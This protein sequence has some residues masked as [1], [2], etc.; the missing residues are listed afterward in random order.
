MIIDK[1]FLRFYVLFTLL[2]LLVCAVL[3]S[4]A[5]EGESEVTNGTSVSILEP[6][7]GGYVQC[8]HSSDGTY[9]FSV[10]GTSTKVYD[11]DKVALLLWVR[12]VMPPSETPGFYLQRKPIN[13][14]TRIEEN[15]HWEGI[16]QIGN[17]V[18]P[19]HAG[20]ILDVAMTVVDKAT[21]ARLLGQT[22][23]VSELNPRGVVTRVRLPGR[24][25]AKAEGVRVKLSPY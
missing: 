25:Q 23:A 14:I 7:S 15:G 1:A 24:G 17:V 16:G 8:S 4:Y 6:K 11:N 12:P 2:L 3:S 10:K 9:H 13:G 21:A 20:D 18:Y 19:P 5:I 22:G